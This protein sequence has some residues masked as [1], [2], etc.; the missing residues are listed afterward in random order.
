ML[1]SLASCSGGGG[2]GSAQLEI[3]R[4]FATGN[5]SFDGGLYIHGKNTTNGEQFSFA[6][7]AKQKAAVT[8]SFGTWEIR[9]IGWDNDPELDPLEG[10]VLCAHETVNFSSNNQALSLHATNA[11]CNSP[12]FAT[13]TADPNTSYMSQ[14]GNLF[15]FKPL[16]VFPCG[17]LYDPANPTQLLPSSL[18]TPGFCSN[19]PAGFQ[20]KAGGVIVSLQTKLPGQLLT[21]GIVSGCMPA[22]VNVSGKPIPT[23]KLLPTKIPVTITL[24]D[25]PTCLDESIIG[26]FH[27]AEG[28]EAIVARTARN[29]DAVTAPTEF[30]TALA[31]QSEP[32]RRGTTPLTT[33]LPFFRCNFAAPADVGEACMKL[34]TVLGGASYV[35]SPGQNTLK[36]PGD[37]SPADITN[38][39][40]EITGKITQTTCV[41]SGDGLTSY[42]SFSLDMTAPE[43]MTS[44]DFGSTLNIY[45]RKNF[46]HVM[47]NLKKIIGWGNQSTVEDSLPNIYDDMET[48]NGDPRG[49]I[50]GN[51]Q[52]PFGPGF[53][54]GFFWDVPCTATPLPA[55]VKKTIILSKH[56]MEEPIAVIVTNPPAHT[57][58]GYIADSNNP[59]GPM[60]SNVFHR[61]YILRKLINSVVGYKTNM[62]MD[63][64]CDG[65]SAW[66]TSV[67]AN[68]RIGRREEF[69]SQNDADYISEE[70]TLLYWNTTYP[71]NSRFE[72]YR[73]S[74]G[75][76]PITL[77]TIADSSFKRAEKFAGTNSNDLKVTDLHY[78]YMGDDV[79]SSEGLH[80]SED[81]ITGLN[82]VTHKVM[83]DIMVTKAGTPESVGSIFNNGLFE[84]EKERMR[85]GTTFNLNNEHTGAFKAGPNGKYIHAY[86]NAIG[87]KLVIVLHNGISLSGQEVAYSADKIAVDM[88]FDGTKA[89]VVASASADLIFY[90]WNGTAWN[91]GSASTSAV[92]ILEALILNNGE[93]LIAVRKSDKKLYLGMGDTSNPPTTFPSA[94]NLTSFYSTTPDEVQEFAMVKTSI[95]AGGSETFHL[96]MN[97]FNTSTTDRVLSTCP[98]K[99][100]APTCT[101]RQIKYAPADTGWAMHLSAHNSNDGKEIII[102]YADA[103]P[104]SPPPGMVP[105]QY[106][107]VRSSDRSV[108]WSTPVTYDATVDYEIMHSPSSFDVFDMTDVTLTPPSITPL[109]V[110]AP[111]IPPVAPG[112]KMNYNG[113][114]PTNMQNVFTPTATF[115]N[116][117]AGL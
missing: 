117:G 81:D 59:N 78:S 72:L 67:G 70:R 32:T 77:S 28:V 113:L 41:E 39:A 27:F 29:F 35:V 100:S 64:A 55:P 83:P 20:K 33:E 3:T 91:N 95:L 16:T 45:V 26:K 75:Y 101:E 66:S 102:S 15:E 7:L 73:Y 2:S 103:T 61:R 84:D 52:D 18:F 98:Y 25:D 65:T 116:I 14:V 71:Q 62:V 94:L 108:T 46:R 76:D 69:Y 97:T 90:V 58:P 44:F 56:G 63:I 85:Y 8:L 48:G 60:A 13:I 54:G 50:L 104:P 43:G 49:G 11:K 57:V 74:H 109:P 24:F 31:L 1:V 93:F 80:Y 107:S 92:E 21:D 82:K 22:H 88:S 51:L 115:E 53:M 79:M 86:P 106:N 12:A 34:P 42:L 4:G 9:A 99:P 114:N 10:D 37:C 89:I 105:T 112:F 96:V 5:A 38:P 6:L 68:S 87:D 40:T 110:M 36:I 23:F 17:A 30:S 19:Y 47:T 111:Y